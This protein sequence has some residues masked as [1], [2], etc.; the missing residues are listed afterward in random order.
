MTSDAGTEILSLWE[1]Q[2][3][4]TKHVDY[5][6]TGICIWNIVKGEDGFEKHNV[7]IPNVSPK[8]FRGVGEPGMES[9]VNVAAKHY[10][11]IHW[12]RTD[13]YNKEQWVPCPRLFA[14]ENAGWMNL[15]WR[16]DLSI[17]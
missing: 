15:T 9:V 2:N 10:H 14:T 17:L 8:L 12:L 5:H 6:F 3:K 1:E 13:F 4:R 7:Q 11:Q 16:M